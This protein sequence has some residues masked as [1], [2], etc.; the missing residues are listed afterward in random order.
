MTGKITQDIIEFAKSAQLSKPELIRLLE[1]SEDWTVD[2]P[3]LEEK[4]DYL[5]ANWEEINERKN[6][7]KDAIL[8]L[9]SYLSTGRMIDFLGGLE[10]IDPIFY[11]KLI[12]SMNE[13]NSNKMPVFSMLLAKRL[14]VIYRL[15]VIPKIFSSERLKAL[16]SE[17]NKL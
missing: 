11:R 2:N 5:F 3:E 8:K 15:M 10:K 7:D 12:D 6:I 4:I 13:L 16:E 9:L 1:S 14:H 17:I